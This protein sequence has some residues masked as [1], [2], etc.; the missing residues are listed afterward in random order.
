M[1]LAGR[2]GYRL[3]LVVVND[4][5]WLSSL[6]RPGTISFVCTEP[7]GEESERLQRPGS[8]EVPGG[9]VIT[10]QLRYSHMLLYMLLLTF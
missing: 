6:F 3:S 4:Q 8:Q 7:E 5:L 10:F 2:A 1:L 9:S